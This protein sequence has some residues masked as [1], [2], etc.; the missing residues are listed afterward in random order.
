M[1]LDERTSHVE[2]TG[3]HHAEP[4]VE[5][6][7][8]PEESD[9]DMPDVQ[10]NSKPVVPPVESPTEPVLLSTQD[11]GPDSTIRRC[12]R[13]TRPPGERWNATI[14]LISSASPADCRQN[15]SWR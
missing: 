3:G 13:Q 10:V 15:G 12:S 5:M 9:A 1:Q 6:S 4:D 14:A 2:S 11:P 7:N 8:S